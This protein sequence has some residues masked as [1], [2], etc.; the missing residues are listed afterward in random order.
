MNNAAILTDIDIDFSKLT[1]G[2]PEQIGND[3]HFCE[4]KYNKKELIFQTPKIQFYSSAYKNKC[5]SISFNN[6]SNNRNSFI[7]KLDLLEKVLKKNSKYLLDKISANVV[8]K[9][10]IQ[11]IKFSEDKTK[12]FLNLNLQI[13]KGIPIVSIYDKNKNKVDLDYI[14]DGSTGYCIIYLRGIWRKDNRMGLSFILVQSKVYLPIYRLDECII[15]DPDIENPILHYHNLVINKPTENTPNKSKPIVKENREEHPIYG[16]YIKMKRMGIPEPAIAIKCSSEGIDFKEFLAYMSGEP[17]I[18][19][20]PIANA[21]AIPQSIN[22]INPMMLQSIQLK[23]ISKEE[24]E[25]QKQKNIMS[26]LK[27]E[28]P[29]GFKPPSSNDLISILK[30]LKKTTILEKDI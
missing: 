3:S 17:I 28:N 5:L 30:K 6:Y 11:S 24:L 2:F 29:S 1:I 22:K 25:L 4:I 7:E 12:V 20:K 19:K 13:D 9:E 15:L 27:I 23:K 14:T 16:K 21:L 18:D 26:R 10:F 8:Q